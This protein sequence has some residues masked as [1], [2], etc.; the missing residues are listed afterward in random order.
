MFETFFE[1]V[2]WVFWIDYICHAFRIFH[3]SSLFAILQ[4]AVDVNGVHQTCN[5]GII[6]VLDFRADRWIEPTGSLL[7][8]VNHYHQWLFKSGLFGTEAVYV[9]LHV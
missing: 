5:V 3:R 4:A 1:P 7:R 6:F 2:Q 9:Q 8:L